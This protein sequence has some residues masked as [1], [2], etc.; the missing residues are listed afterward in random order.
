VLSVLAHPYLIDENLY[1][2]DIA[3]DNR[4]SYIENLITSGLDGIKSC[5]TY[6]KTTYKGSLSDNRIE[7]IIE[8]KYRYK[9]RFFTG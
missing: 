7:E 4:E 2:K 8:N 5:Y 1:S 6:S 9:I 3:C